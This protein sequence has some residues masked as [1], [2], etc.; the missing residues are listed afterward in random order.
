MG[1]FTIVI[2]GLNIYVRVTYSSFY[3]E[4]RE[5]FVEPGLNEGFIPQDIDYLNWGN[6][7]LFSGY[8]GNGLA[9]PIYKELDDN[10][11]AKLTISMPDGSIYDGH[12]SGITS[13]GEYVFL[14]C[15]EG[16]L[17]LDAQTIVEAVDGDI[18]PA[19]AKC[20]LDFSPAF[21]NVENDTLYTGNFYYPVAYETPEH[22]HIAT[23]DSQENPAVLYAYPADPES[24][25]GFSSTASC[26]YSIPG[27]VQGICFT[28]GTIVLSTSYGIASS[29]LLVYESDRLVQEG[30][31]TADGLE[32]PLYI[33]DSRSL[34]ED[35]VAPPMTEGIK[36]HDGR[37]Y[38]SNESATNKY[39]FG[40]LY[41]A[42]RVYSIK[43]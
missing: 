43:I 31:F 14:T 10:T 21:M 6:C 13:K 41:G 18:I 40:K 12:G 29:H 8:M 34:I 28:G 3:Q 35:I 17:V 39:I 42:T 32:V 16:Y 24:E 36:T 11:Y 26:V 38:I 25:Y 30:L 22:H 33:L 7:W 1:L 37:I 15:E 20:D 27:K 2:I 23:A 9:S 5:E 19:L 4:A